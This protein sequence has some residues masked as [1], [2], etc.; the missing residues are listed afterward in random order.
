MLDIWVY[1]LGQRDRLLVHTVMQKRECIEHSMQF[2]EKL[3]ELHP[4]M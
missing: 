1:I 4:Q 3:G 2:S